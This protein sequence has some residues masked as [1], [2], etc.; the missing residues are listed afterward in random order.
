MGS[1][2]CIRDRRKGW[3]LL[4]TDDSSKCVEEELDVC[5]GVALLCPG[6]GRL[7]VLGLE[8]GHRLVR[9]YD[10][11][12]LGATTKSGVRVRG[13]GAQP[14]E[15]MESATTRGWPGPENTPRCVRSGSGVA[16]GVSHLHRG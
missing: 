15:V 4:A 10:S 16:G 7:E 1:E 13:R 6:R 11:D 12:D 8:K 9:E 14:C 2:M 5:R 3:L